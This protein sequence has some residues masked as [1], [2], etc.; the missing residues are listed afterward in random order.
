MDEPTNN[1][2][3]LNRDQILAADDIEFET[4]LTPEW[5]KNSAVRVKSMTGAQRDRLSQRTQAGADGKMPL[6]H[7]HARVCAMT[8]CDEAGRL[9]FSQ[10]D[11]IALSAKSIKP[12]DRI[13]KTAMDISAI[14]A[15]E[16]EE[17]EGNSEAAA[18]GDSNLD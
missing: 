10:D 18:S 12:L 6:E 1:I 13:F 8:V 11:L 4:V 9:I 5:G 17:I 14:D 2:V 15:K 16:Q 7:I 3:F